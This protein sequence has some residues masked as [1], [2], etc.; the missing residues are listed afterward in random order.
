MRQ[1]LGGGALA[2][3]DEVAGVALP[4]AF[5][6]QV[7]A[8][9]LVMDDDA[10]V[11]AE[12]RGE[13]Q[14]V[15]PLGRG[16]V[17]QH[18]R[19]A[20]AEIPRD[21]PLGV[22]AQA[23]AVDDLLH[24]DGLL[25]AHAVLTDASPSPPHLLQQLLAQVAVGDGRGHG[26][27]VGAGGDGAGEVGE[28]LFLGDLRGVAVVDLL[29]EDGPALL[30]KH[31]HRLLGRFDLGGH[32]A[33]GDDV[34]QDLAFDLQHTPI[35]QKTKQNPTFKYEV[36]TAGIKISF[37]KLPNVNLAAATKVVAVTT[38]LWHT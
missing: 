31:V 25:D 22:Q 4:V 10:L 24:G 37:L 18:L 29:G 27:C 35:K 21:A 36:Y 38:C 32:L 20:G 34:R 33:V 5:A 16:V 13:N 12:V 23:L 26:G 3:D 28:H 17:L 11:L 9:A 7:Q 2:A 15:L 8:A 30:T 19:D 1:E 14:V 6:L